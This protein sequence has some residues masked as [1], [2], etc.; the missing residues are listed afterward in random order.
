ML[1]NSIQVKLVLTVAIY[2]IFQPDHCETVLKDLTTEMVE[3][4]RITVFADVSW[5]GS[6][7]KDINWLTSLARAA[8]AEGLL[9]FEIAAQGI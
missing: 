7:K 4:N 2:V 5:G 1:E 6:R 3:D 9:S 8:F